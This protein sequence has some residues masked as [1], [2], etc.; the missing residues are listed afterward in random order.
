MSNEW[1]TITNDPDMHTLLKNGVLA[2]SPY[3]YR[4]QRRKKEK[5]MPPILAGDCVTIGSNSALRY[6]LNAAYADETTIY[7]KLQPDDRTGFF[8]SDVS[9]IYR[10][11]TEIWRRE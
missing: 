7:T 11:G 10:S 2:I 9:R 3:E 6:V 4:L 5:V 1:E 8:K